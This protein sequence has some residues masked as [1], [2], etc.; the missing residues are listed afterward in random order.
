MRRKES[1]ASKAAGQAGRDRKEC[2]RE[3]GGR[4]QHA[5]LPVGK[6]FPFLSSKSAQSK[7]KKGSNYA[8]YRVSHLVMDLGWVDLDLASSPGWGA[9]TVANLLPRQGGGTSKI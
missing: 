1:R 7:E 8:V 3:S 2:T 5:R 9:A 4:P 6:I